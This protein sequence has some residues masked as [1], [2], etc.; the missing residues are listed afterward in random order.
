M[1][2]LFLAS[3]FLGCG[4]LGPP[5]SDAG[6]PDAGI[7][8]GGGGGGGNAMTGGGG[9]ALGPVAVVPLYE[10]RGRLGARSVAGFRPWRGGL[11][12]VGDALYWV[13]SGA[14]AG[15]YRAPL[16]GCDGGACVD[17]VTTLTRPSV[18]A[19]AADSVLLADVTALRRYPSSDSVA[20]GS[21]ELLTLA[22]DGQ[23]AF[24]TTEN[25]PVNRTPFGGVTSTPIHSNGTPYAMTVAGDRVYWAGVDIS[26]QLGALQSIR[27]DGTGAREESRFSNGF[28]A[29]KGNATYLYYARDTPAR[30]F[31]ITLS[32]GLLEEVANN[33]QGV[34]DLA[35]DDTYA[36][37]VEPGGADLS[38]GRVRR[39]AHE[40]TSAELVAQSLAY[41][42]AIAVRDGVLFVASAGT[43]TAQWADGRILRITLR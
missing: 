33:A 27:T 21:S 30:L 1:R 42:V 8:G 15:L 5:R 31:R 38:N 43:Q 25:S 12:V 17:V 40:S 14:T 39:V 32:N 10:G 13:E 23:A 22:T 20:T 16:T 7:F 9:G 26:G 41:P 34:T 28:H 36:Y 11:A 3:V 18:F 35:L 4:A 37:W 19:A 2:A 29:M 24:W 6:V